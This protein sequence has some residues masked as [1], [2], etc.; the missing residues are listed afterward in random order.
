MSCE[1]GGTTQAQV[2]EASTPEQRT[3]AQGCN[4]IAQ[5]LKEHYV[6]TFDILLSNISCTSLVRPLNSRGLANVQASISDKGFL[7][8]HAPSV[9]V[10]SEQMRR[11]QT[12]GLR[13]QED[14]D[15]LRFAVIDG[16]HRVTG[17]RNALGSTSRIPCRVYKEFSRQDSRI[18]ANGKALVCSR[19]VGH[20]G[21]SSGKL[22]LPDFV[23]VAASFADRLIGLS[24]NRC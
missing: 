21:C 5:T 6:G 4:F 2:N 17:A 23:L 24:Q 15:S 20:R 19:G 14:V 11:F 16:N 10:A 7:A 1:S 13:L 18:I 12:S 22:V 3:A 9:T 8:Q